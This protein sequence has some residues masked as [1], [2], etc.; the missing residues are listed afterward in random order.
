MASRVSDRGQITIDRDVREKLGVE[1]GMIAYQR[2]VDGRLEVVF[3]PAPHRRSLY[4][5]FHDP[6]RAPGPMTGSELETSVIEAI[7][8]EQSERKVDIV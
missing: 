1:P 6:D 7:D 4:G 5:V 3:L 8:A 2:I